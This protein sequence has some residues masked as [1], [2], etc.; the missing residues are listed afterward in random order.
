VTSHVLGIDINQK[1]DTASNRCN[2]SK[3]G[4][5]AGGRIVANNTDGKVDR[6]RPLCRYPQVAAYEGTSSTDAWRVRLQNA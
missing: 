2:C 1:S 6:T 5:A 3:H 4:T